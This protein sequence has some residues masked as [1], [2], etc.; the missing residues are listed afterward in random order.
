MLGYITPDSRQ[1]QY[2]SYKSQVDSLR[3]S[4]IGQKFNLRWEL[5]FI[6]Y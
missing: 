5:K 3:H 2:G 4:G 1:T 6:K